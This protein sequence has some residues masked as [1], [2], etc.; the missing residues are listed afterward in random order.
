MMLKR[1]EKHF[2]LKVLQC[3]MCLIFLV[4]CANK[5]TTDI[6]AVNDPYI[7]ETT[8]GSVK[9]IL[10][11]ST[12]EAEVKQ[13]VTENPRQSDTE[14]RA[15]EMLSEMT[16]EEKVYQMFFITPEQLTGVG[17][18]VAAGT[19]TKEA[20]EKYPVG[21]IIYFSQNIVSR[22]QTESMIKNLQSYSRIPVFTGV[23]EEGGMV[24]RIGSNLNMGTTLFPNMQEIGNSGDVKQ[25][26]EV[27][28]VIG[29]EC[30]GL[31]F[32]LDFAPVADVF[33][34]PNNTVI[35]ARAF[36]TDAQIA[37]DM[38]ESCVKGFHDANMLCTLKHFPGHGDTLTDSHYGAAVTNK[39]LD[40]LRNNEFLPFKKGIQAGADF[41]MVGHILTPNITDSSTPA[42]LSGIMIS[43]LRDELQFDG[44]IITDAMNMAAISDVH[45]S[46]EASVE[47][48]QAGVDMILMPV[49]FHD[50][51]T[52]VMNA[53]KNG[54]LKET[55]IDDSVLRIL[56]AKINK[57][58]I[59]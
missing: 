10:E 33:S 2:L 12:T 26:Y 40:E 27:G 50:A 28:H 37:A 29:T 13:E 58:I 23:D 6:S 44:V 18:V 45:S 11:E 31:G 47:A 24:S 46:S 54:E 16:L 53:L 39:T 5:E 41:V 20:I 14:C 52:G 49:D 55:T 56:C 36:S 21:G 1:S 48:I 51:V 4:G 8:Y 57:G 22:E 34:N 30:R 19:T 25:A 7:E 35:G 59:V 9:E 17:K 32:N 43:I 3:T 15:R 42:T 38:V